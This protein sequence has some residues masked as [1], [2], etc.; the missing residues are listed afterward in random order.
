[1]VFNGFAWS[2][3]LFQINIFVDYHLNITLYPMASIKWQ[4]FHSNSIT[5][6]FKTSDLIKQ[7]FMSSSYFFLLFFLS[8]V[9]EI[10]YKT[11]QLQK[12]FIENF[13]VVVQKRSN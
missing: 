3:K 5:T 11:E 9:W 6:K 10:P 7:V 2:K 1:M 8:Y 4:S 13:R 12:Q